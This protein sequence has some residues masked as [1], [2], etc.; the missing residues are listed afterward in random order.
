MYMLTISQKSILKVALLYIILSIGL[1]SYLTPAY[2]ATDTRYDSGLNLPFNEKAGNV[3]PQTGNLTVE[4]TD[5]ELPGRA[6]LNFKFGRYWNLNQSNAFTMYRDPYDGSNKLN[7]ETL[8]QYN[9]MG[10]G[11]STN[12]PY[13][14]KDNSSGVQVINLCFSGSVYELDPSGL[15]LYKSKI[16]PDKSNILWYDLLD[17]R[18]YQESGIQYS[19]YSGFAAIPAEYGVADQGSAQNQYVLI[20][21]DNSKYW[22]RA[23]GQLMMQEDRTG[24]NRIW[25]FYDNQARLKLVVDTA[26]RMIRFGYDAAGNLASLEWDVEIGVK[27]SNGSRERKTETRRIV[28]QYESAEKFNSVVNLKPYVV[29]YRQPYL[30]KSVTDPENCLISYAYS[31]GSAYFTYDSFK[32]RSQSV[33]IL[34]HYCPVMDRIIPIVCL[35]QVLKKC[36]LIFQTVDLIEFSQIDSH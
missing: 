32:E 28:Y 8:E 23:D 16:N 22:F 30:L 34:L 35:N 1:L 18:V 25:Y 19:D 4:V 27:N 6:G 36:N 12:L 24:L 3:N 26:E 13:I 7:S 14:F 21:K 9:R 10:V 11:W 15:A 31:D 5:L 2:A 33:Y 20:L 29:N 17:L